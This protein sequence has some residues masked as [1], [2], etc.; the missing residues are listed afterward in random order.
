MD[1]QRTVFPC[2]SLHDRLQGKGDSAGAGPVSPC[3]ERGSGVALI[4]QDRSV[5]L[6]SEERCAMSQLRAWL[7]QYFE[8]HGRL[9]EP[10]ST[11]S[12]MLDMALEEEIVSIAM[13]VAAMR[14]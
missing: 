3:E 9:P 14:R 6:F 8:E 12:Q 11:F 10:S 13:D 1:E 5:S 4:Q 7:W 2:I